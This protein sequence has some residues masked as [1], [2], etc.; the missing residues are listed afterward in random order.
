MAPGV[1]SGWTQGGPP[2]HRTDTD[3]VRVIYI[4]M[5]YIALPGNDEA[6]RTFKLRVYNTLH[7]TAAA[8]RVL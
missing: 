6:L 4:D 3:D 8:T 5:V 1:E 2:S 7:T